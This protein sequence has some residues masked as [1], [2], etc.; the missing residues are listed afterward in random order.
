LADTFTGILTVDSFERTLVSIGIFCKKK[1]EEKEGWYRS[2]TKKNGCEFFL[3]I[4]LKILYFS[5]RL[6]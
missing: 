2:W 1:K 3:L 6:V 4:L 5:K